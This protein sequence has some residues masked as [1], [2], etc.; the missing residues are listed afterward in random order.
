LY[1]EV[2]CR[3]GSKQP[4]VAIATCSA[5]PELTADDSLLVEALAA[6]GMRS[7]PLWNPAE[8]M[9]WNSSKEYLNALAARGIPT[10]P[11]HWVSRGSE[12]R[13]IDVLTSHGWEDA[14][15]KPT[16]DLG[17]M[18]LRR[19][20]GKHGIEQIALE[21]LLANHDVMIQPFLSSVEERGE[22]SLVY[23]GG[24]SIWSAGP[25]AIPA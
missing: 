6:Q 11:T 24:E 19:V 15:I 3:R 14:V 5:L 17:A 7:E 9:I 20:N 10:I 21:A 22:T 18:N 25:V 2:R 23:V 16:V 1:G 12:T 4:V 13:L 8:T